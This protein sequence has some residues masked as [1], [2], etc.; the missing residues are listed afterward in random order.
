MVL[1]Q[2][3][4]DVWSVDHR[5]PNTLGNYATHRICEQSVISE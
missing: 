3:L 5:C 4:G 2:I 1:F